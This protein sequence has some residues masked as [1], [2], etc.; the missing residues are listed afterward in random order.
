MGIFCVL[1]SFAVS[2]WERYWRKWSQKEWDTQHLFAIF[3]QIIL[4]SS[5]KSAEPIKLDKMDASGGICVSW[6]AAGSIIHKSRN[7][8]PRSI[9][10]FTCTLCKKS[11]KA[12]IAPCSSNLIRY[13]SDVCVERRY[14]WDTVKSMASLYYICRANALTTKFVN[15]LGYATDNKI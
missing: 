5:S 10:S 14:A 7:W 8:T 11:K 1:S 12:L 13:F 2:I 15:S 4:K 9:I 6:S 3:K